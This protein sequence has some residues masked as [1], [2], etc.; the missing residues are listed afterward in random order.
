MLYGTG[1]G[2]IQATNSNML[3]GILAILSTAPFFLA[4]FETIPQGVEDAGGDIKSVGK[5]VVLSVALACI[6]YAILL[7]CFGFAWPW[8]EF[9]HSTA[10]G[11]EMTNPAAATVLRMFTSTAAHRRGPVLDHHHRRSGRPVHHLE[12][13]LHGLRPAADGHG[14]WPSDAQNLRSSEQ[15]RHPLFPLCSSA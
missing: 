5:T 2:Y 15:E 10:V 8:Q 14:P 12:R 11:G 7:F 3:G 9:S 6:F 4:G 13:L 1:E